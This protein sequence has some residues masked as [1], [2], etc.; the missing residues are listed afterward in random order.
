MDVTD[1]L[2][3]SEMS[4]RFDRLVDSLHELFELSVWRTE[5]DGSM[6]DR[7]AWWQLTGQNASDGGPW[8]HLA[9]VHP[10]DRSKVRDAWDAAIRTGTHR[11]DVRVSL[12]GRYVQARSHALPIRDASGTVSGWIGV[13]TFLAPPDTANR[14]LP[15]ASDGHLL[16]A[17][18][19]RGAR[20]LLDWTARELAERSGV[21][22]STVRRVETRGP[23]T[24]RDENLRVVR[25]TF[26][27]HGVEF[28]VL[29]DGRPGLVLKS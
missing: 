2:S 3:Q 17:V 29:A 16:T 1:T 5:A 27:R 8:A 9:D 21:S 13:T 4:Q 28:I 19:V 15:D 12:H 10:D 24:V 7:A 25:T 26:E 20:G 18:Q 11:C 23:R 6:G 14:P 22:Y